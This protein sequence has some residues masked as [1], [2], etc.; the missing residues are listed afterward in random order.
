M[1]YLL[2]RPGVSRPTGW[3]RLEEAAAECGWE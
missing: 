2:L 3:R 1:L